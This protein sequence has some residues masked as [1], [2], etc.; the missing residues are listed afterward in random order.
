M[1]RRWLSALADNARV[2]ADYPG[3][4]APFKETT[5]PVRIR[6]L[7]WKDSGELAGADVRIMDGVLVLP[8][9]RGALGTASIGGNTRGLFA[10][11]PTGETLRPD[12]L[13][14][15]DPQSKAVAESPAG[16]RQTVGKIESDLFNLAG[17]DTR[18]SVMVACTVIAEN[19]VAE[20]FLKHPDFEPVRVGQVLTWPAGFEDKS[21]D[22]RKL[23]EAWNIERVEGM[24]DHDG[25]KRART[26]YAANKEALT[27]G[28]SVSWA[29]RLDRKRGDPDASFAAMWD[30]YRLGEAAFMAERQNA[31]MQTETTVYNLTPELVASRVHTGRR[32]CDVPS[33]ARLLVMAT[34]LN[35]YGLHSVIVGFGND[36]TGWIVAYGRHDNAGREIVPKDLP[37]PEAK[38]RVFEALV[39]HG[40]ELSTLPLLRNGQT[41][42]PGL[43][44]VDAGFMPDVVRRYAEGPARTLGM[45]VMPARGFNFDRYRPSP[46][47]CIGSPREMCHLTESPVA[48]RFV[49]FNA[50]YWREVSQRAW[51]ATP[52]APGSLSLFE[53]KHAEF[54]EQVTRERLLEKL[55]GEFGTVWRWRTAPGWHDFSD[56]VTMAYVAA[57]WGGI[58]TAAGIPAPTRRR[59]V[60]RRRCNITH[61]PL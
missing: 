52:N 32:R 28:L 46:K 58:G 54:S 23:W 39:R 38:R 43:W 55:H 35:F 25:G 7:R 29:H 33:E 16:V 19:D 26:F 6:L 31:P 40:Q 51:L 53:G 9:G 57:A 44:I 17:P 27:A 11:M 12:V 4:T 45:P 61:I 47:N 37:E 5:H 15:D 48:G 8:D 24:A 2:L 42:R 21:S 13:F 22:A 34:D 18:L 3:D 41:M 14:L 36:G 20:H 59:Y 10:T 60:E 56:A 50:C 1:L 30:F 49:A